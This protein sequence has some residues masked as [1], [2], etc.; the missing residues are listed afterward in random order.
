MS[1]GTGRQAKP[2]SL[3]WDPWRQSWRHQTLLTPKPSATLAWSRRIRHPVSFSASPSH[4]HPRSRK[5][6]SR[7]LPPPREK[8]AGVKGRP[9]LRPLGSAK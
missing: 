7:S 3:K 8:T 2:I 9:P 1:G 6:H 5:S 4:R